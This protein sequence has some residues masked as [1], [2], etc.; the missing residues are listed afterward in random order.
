FPAVVEAIRSLKPKTL[1]LD[2]ELVIFDRKKVSR[3]QLLQQGSGNAVYAAFDCLFADGKDLRRL[4]LAERRAAL[5]KIIGKPGVLMASRRL[6]KNGI[7]AY[8]DAT[9]RNFEGIVAKD[10][11]A[12]YFE[13]RST[14]WLKVKVHQED[15]FVV[16][17]YTKPDGAR[18]YFGALLLGAYQDGKLRYVGKVG[19]GFDELSLAALHKAFQPL[20]SERTPFADPPR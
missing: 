16:A 3:F 18:R 13:G 4:P 8:R 11:K 7:E 20:R 12:P 6:A 5:E 14:N 19:T 10:A 17:G 2:G 9:R 15:E 1:L